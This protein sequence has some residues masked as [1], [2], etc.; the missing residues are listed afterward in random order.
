MGL[1]DAPQPIGVEIKSH[2]LHC[3]ICRH[4]RFHRHKIRLDRAGLFT[5]DWSDPMAVSYECAYCG[6]LHWFM[7]Q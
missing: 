4:P 1:F 2:A 5:S 3:V 6:Y 7:P